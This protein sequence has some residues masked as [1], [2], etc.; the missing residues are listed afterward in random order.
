MANASQLLSNQ[1]FLLILDNF[2]L[3]R[4]IN[5]KNH[6]T[7]WRFC[8]P[9]EKAKAKAMPGRLYI[10]TINNNNNQQAGAELCQAQAQVGLTAELI[11]VLSS[12]EA[13]FH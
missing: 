1:G 7:N 11:L 12:M 5:A 3:V 13:V 4:Q 2:N 6:K 8:Q 9:K 10:H